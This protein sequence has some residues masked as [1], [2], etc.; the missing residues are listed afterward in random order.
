MP[1]VA[2]DVDRFKQGLSKNQKR[3]W[4]KIANKVLT[5]CRAKGNR[6][7]QCD[8]VAIRTANSAAVKVTEQ[9]MEQLV[10]AGLMF[11]KPRKEAEVIAM[12]VLV[13]QLLMDTP[14]Q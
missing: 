9:R 7:G 8:G 6:E 12:D 10:K 1:F 3:A 14:W 13:E 11:D 5:D 2:G 4:V